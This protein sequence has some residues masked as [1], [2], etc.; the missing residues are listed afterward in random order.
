MIDAFRRL[1]SKDWTCAIA[2]RAMDDSVERFKKQSQGLPIEFI[3]W[4]EP[5]QFFTDIDVL[6]V[7][8]FWAEPSP[9]TIYESYMM[10]VPVIG[11]RSGGIPELIGDA[12]DDWLFEPGND[13]DL[14]AKIA[15]VIESGRDT[16]P[17]ESSF[18]RVVDESTA[19]RVAEKYLAL[20]EELL[21]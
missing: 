20:Y 12:N 17:D 19:S 10:G 4:A 15:R 2:G 9:R 3:G 18:K 16:L 14:A 7:P 11:A 8:S 5:K 21:A 13:A 6:I 1:K